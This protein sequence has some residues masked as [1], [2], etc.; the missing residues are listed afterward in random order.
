MGEPQF[1][2]PVCGAAALP[3]DQL[4]NGPRPTGKIQVGRDRTGGPRDHDAFGN[5]PRTMA[6]LYREA[7]EA[8]GQ[9][10]RGKG[11]DRYV[12]LQEM[13]VEEMQLLRVA[14]TECGRTDDHLHNVL[15]MRQELEAV[16]SE[17]TVP[18]EPPYC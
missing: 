11:V 7:D 5:E 6:H 9:L 3:V 8:G 12:Y 18:V 13:P 17:P 14:D 2:Q 15:G 1:C 10:D 4:R 16:V